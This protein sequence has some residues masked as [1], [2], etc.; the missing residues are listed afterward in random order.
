MPT[1]EYHCPT[2]GR[3]IEVWHSMRETLTQWG[4]LCER[5]GLEAGGTPRQAAIQKNIT[6][7]MLLN[8][9]GS[10]TSHSGGSCCGDSGCAG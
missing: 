6:T 3:T 7:G 5:A 10:K 1:Y 8:K 4:E 2:N 9:P